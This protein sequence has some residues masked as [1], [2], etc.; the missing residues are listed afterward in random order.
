MSKAH[1]YLMKDYETRKSQLIERNREQGL[2]KDI[3]FCNWGNSSSSPIYETT[4]K[5]YI[6][7]F[8]NFI[9]KIKK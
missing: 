2:Y 9:K 8:I 7:D 5:N 1:K 6:I 3:W 4:P